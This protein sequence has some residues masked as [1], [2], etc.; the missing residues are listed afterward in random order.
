MSQIPWQTY[1]PGTSY[2][3][4]ERRK[5][6]DGSKSCVF[7]TYNYIYKQM[8]SYSYILK[9]NILFRLYPGLLFHSL[10][11]SIQ[12]LFAVGYESVYVSVQIFNILILLRASWFTPRVCIINIAYTFYLHAYT[13]DRK[14]FIYFCSVLVY[15]VVSKRCMVHIYLKKKK[16]VW[17]LLFLFWRNNLLFRL[18]GRLI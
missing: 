3:W 7:F 12:S 6:S 16:F 11:G 1:K 10:E 13:I 2:G 17:F 14:Y 4:K 18:C 8:N 9:C 15:P 5:K